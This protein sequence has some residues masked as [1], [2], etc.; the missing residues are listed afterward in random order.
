MGFLDKIKGKAGDAAT[1][2]GDK[3]S[4]GLDKAGE[5]VDK[6]T[7]GKYSDKIVM[8]K[9]KVGEG[10]GKLDKTPDMTSTT[11]TAATTTGPSPSSPPSSDITDTSVNDPELPPATAETTLASGDDLNPLL[12]DRNPP[13]DDPNPPPPAPTYPAAH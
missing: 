7:K 4:G 2:H 10:L 13:P 12:D 5:F 8:G 1:K 3:I 11:T 6:K 9:E